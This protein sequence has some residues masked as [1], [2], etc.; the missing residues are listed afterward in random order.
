MN[1]KNVHP[2]YEKGI[3]NQGISAPRTDKPQDIAPKNPQDS[4]DR[5]ESTRTQEVQ[6]R[7]MPELSTAEKQSVQ[8][9]EKYLSSVSGEEIRLSPSQIRNRF[10]SEQEKEPSSHI[11][12]SA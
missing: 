3:Q 4:E 1:V 10:S 7:D 8:R 2:I 5:F 6:H 11:D 12:Y 9:L